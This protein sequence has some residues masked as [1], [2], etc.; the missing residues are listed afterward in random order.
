MQ[1][2][3]GLAPGFALYRPDVPPDQFDATDMRHERA[4]IALDRAERDVG[5]QVMNR[6]PT[7]VRCD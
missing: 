6:A 2:A 4:I 1:F 7:R 5:I 3:R